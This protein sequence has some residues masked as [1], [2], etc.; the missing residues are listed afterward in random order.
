M[1]RIPISYRDLLR[2]FI[3]RASLR[4]NEREDL[5]AALE[6]DSPA[7]IRRTAKRMV[8]ILLERG[9]LEITESIEKSD[10]PL[11]RLRVPENGLRFTIRIDEPVRST[12]YDIIPLPL[13]PRP[14][15]SVRA[16]LVRQLVN[17]QGNLVLSDR[18]AGPRE[19]LH[20]LEPAIRDALAVDSVVLLPIEHPN[21]QF[22][23]NLT[24]ESL[25]LPEAHLRE[26][27]QTRTHLIQVRDF[28]QHDS[29][30]RTAP[31]TGSAIYI[32]IGDD[33]GG[34]RGVVEARDHRADAFSAE[35]IELAVLLTGYLQ[36]LLANAV[37]LQ[38][39][40]FFDY[41]TGLHNRSYFEDQ[42]EKMVSAAS[43]HDQ[44]F[45]L[46][47]VDIDDFK[48]FNTLYGYEGG[49]R[50]LATVGCILK[51]GLRTSDTIARYGGEEFAALL[52][53]PVTPEEAYAIAERLRHQVQI[54][55]FQVQD[56]DGRFVPERITVSIGGALFPTDGTGTR[57][58]WNS[59]NRLLLEAKALGKNR[60]RFPDDVECG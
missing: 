19:V 25:P 35:R 48:N 32:G 36:T 55:P 39:L 53:P 54:E 5:E 3:P 38:S 37:R 52:A 42:L 30:R 17:E 27:A 1:R 58:I 6:S 15:A 8:R 50:V 12:G 51:A 24:P 11:L 26:L 59:A 9:A 46:C 57:G 2:D 14:I 28:S 45:A 34:W 33:A 44:Q 49:D 60:V 4:E 29:G 41:L 47:I 10:G 31:K 16:D 21:E 56:L 43:R 20:R 7:E 40:M 23:G 18:V 22:W 13:V